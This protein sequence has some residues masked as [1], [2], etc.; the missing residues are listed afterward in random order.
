MARATPDDPGPDLHDRIFGVPVAVLGPDGDPSP[1]PVAPADPADPA[2]DVD[3]DEDPDATGLWNVADS[4][5][6]ALDARLPQGDDEVGGLFP[7]AGGVVG[8]VVEDARVWV[9]R[10]VPPRQVDVRRLGPRRTAAA[11]AV[12]TLLG[13][14]PAVGYWLATVTSPGVRTTDVLASPSSLAAT[15]TATTL[16]VSVTAPADGP[17]PTGYTITPAGSTAQD[18]T[19]SGGGPGPAATCVVSGLASGTSYTLAVRSTLGA[20]VS[21]SSTALTTS[22]APAPAPAVPVLVS[23]SDTGT[24]STDG[25]TSDTTPTLTGGAAAGLAGAT[26]TVLDGSVGVAVA[27]AAVD[28]SWTATVDAGL[29]EGSHLLTAVAALNGGGRGRASAATT[30]RV[31]TTAPTAP[32]VAAGT[33][34]NGAATNDTNGWYC[35]AATFASSAGLQLS[36]AATD[37][38]GI[39]AYWFDTVT[40]SVAMPSTTPSPQAGT[41]IAAGA[42][43]SRIL[44]TAGYARVGVA[45]VDLAG[46]VSATATV[47]AVVDLTAPTVGEATAT[48]AGTVVNDWCRGSLRVVLSGFADAGPAS[49]ATAAA[50]AVAGGTAGTAPLATSSGTASGEFLVSAPDGTPAFTVT[51]RDAA[52]NTSAAAPFTS[53]VALDNTAPRAAAVALSG[54]DGTA[55]QGDTVTL[56]LTDATSGVDPRTVWD[57]WSA[58]TTPTVSTGGLL[59]ATITDHG[60]A[61]TL[62]FS[63]ASGTLALGS[64]ALGADYVTGAP[65][66]F[67]GYGSDATTLTWSGGTVTVTLG[68]PSRTANT[69]TGS[70]AVTWTPPPTVADL[71]GNRLVAAPVG[72]TGRF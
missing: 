40:S 11:I 38:V 29:A 7:T 36:F 32:T 51:A 54:A 35:R 30:L 4:Q 47:P 28:G 2:A 46:N 24:S 5:P 60:A 37:A 67:G 70:P 3:P 43:T 33:C 62:T 65:V 55:G 17:A 21:D 18:C 57:G 61:D 50:W 52:G 34:G 1:E 41:S 69:V 25:I 39:D 6:A 26:I 15:A 58:G 23:T 68:R 9:R 53:T 8:A 48:C 22:T 56:A 13:A 19:M 10:G 42:A 45:A 59:T 20:Q 49:L 12:G 27:T 16:T 66:T 14:S 72:T 64:V 44:G 31:D 71:A 63:A